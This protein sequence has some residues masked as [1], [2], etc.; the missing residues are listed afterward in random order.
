[1]KTIQTT[2]LAALAA[3]LLCLLAGRSYA[4]GHE[5]LIIS[6]GYFHGRDSGAPFVPRGFSYQV[7]NPAVYATQDNNQISYDLGEIKAIRANSLRVEFVWGELEQKSGDSATDYR[8]Q[9]STK[10]TF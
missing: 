2:R 4:I 7:F 6:N 1:M 5:Y 8:L 10:V 3:G 9:F